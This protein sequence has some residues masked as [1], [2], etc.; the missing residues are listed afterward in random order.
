MQFVSASALKQLYTEHYATIGEQEV[1]RLKECLLNYLVNK[2][3][4]CEQQV[5]KM[6][7]ML[8]V[9]VVKIGWYEHPQMQTL[10][11]DLIKFGTLGE[12]HLLISLTAMEE[13]IIEMGYVTRGKNLHAHRRISVN[14]RDTQL[15]AILNQSLEFV[16]RYSD[17]VSTQQAF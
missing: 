5:L 9:K 1:L 8:L 16:R 3:C 13:L 17:Q 12:R 4:Q 11:S 7:V 10:V 15:F 14:F 6:V 2:G